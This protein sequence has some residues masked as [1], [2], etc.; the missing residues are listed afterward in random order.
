[1]EVVLGMPFFTLSNADIQFAEK[2]IIWRFYTTK[3]DLFTT[4]RVELIHKKEFARA[5]LD[6]EFKTFVVHVAALGASLVGMT[7]HPLQ[8]A[9]IAALKQNET[10]T[11]MSPKYADYAGIFSFDLAMKLFENT[12]INKHALKMQDRKQLP[13]RPIYS[14]EPVELET[15][16]TY[17]ET[18]LKTGFIWPLKFPASVS[19]LFDKKP[20]SSLRLCVN[21]QGL[22]NLIIKNRYLLP[23]IEESLDQ[24]GRA[25][26]FI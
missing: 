14:L 10:S 23:L 8:T 9:Q 26:R 2:E 6:E 11:K 21:Y 17:I 18:H 25:K 22:N 5:A 12:D 3:E 1:M 20:D 7:I 15:L 16:K 19:I 13:Y 4:Q 24:L